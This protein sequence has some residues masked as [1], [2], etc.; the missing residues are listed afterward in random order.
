MV[1]FLKLT[2]RHP[3]SLYGFRDPTRIVLSI[4]GLSMFDMCPDT[5]LLKDTV[6]L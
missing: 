6:E 1:R 2:A 3:S 4:E 5:F